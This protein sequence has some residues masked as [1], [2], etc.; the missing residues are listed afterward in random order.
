VIEYRNNAD[1][2][3]SL[4]KNK[5]LSKTIKLFMEAKMKKRDYGRLLQPVCVA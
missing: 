5:L 2:S 1:C 3:G 4:N